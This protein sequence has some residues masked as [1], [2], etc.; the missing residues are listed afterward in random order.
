MQN[1]K[2]LFKKKKNKQHS[3]TFIILYYL[4]LQ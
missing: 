2:T 3:Q 1:Q 4:Q